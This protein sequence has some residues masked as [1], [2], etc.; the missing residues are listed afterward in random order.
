[1]SEQSLGD[2]TVTVH[3]D[4][5][6]PAPDPAPDVVV[7]AP[8]AGGVAEEMTGALE[9]AEQVRAIARE[10]AYRIVDERMALQPDLGDVVETAAVVAEQVAEEVVEEAEPEPEPEPE[11]TP[12][13]T[14]DPEPKKTH[15]W[16]R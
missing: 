3:V 14:P 15:W 8:D 9:F 13:P 16:F 11:P 6:A 2:A 10:E 5:P 7:V 4:P 1:M 12:P